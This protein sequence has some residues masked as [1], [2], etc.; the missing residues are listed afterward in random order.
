MFVL[1]KSFALTGRQVSIGITWTCG[2]III[3]R[4][5][6]HIKS[7]YQIPKA[8]WMQRVHVIIKIISESAGPDVQAISYCC[9]SL[10]LLFRSADVNGIF[11]MWQDEVCPALRFHSGT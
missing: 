3:L 11:E 4:V 10:L 2:K 9:F 5:N 6:V 7:S 8:H 1:H